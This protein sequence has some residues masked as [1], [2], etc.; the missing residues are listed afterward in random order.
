MEWKFNEGYIY[1]LVP[2]SSFL[3]TD[4]TRQYIY[5]YTYQYLCIPTSI[6]YT[7]YVAV[8]VRMYVL[9]NL[10]KFEIFV[11]W[12]YHGRVVKRSARYSGYGVIGQHVSR[13]RDYVLQQLSRSSRHCSGRT[14]WV[15]AYRRRKQSDI[16]IIIWQLLYFSTDRNHNISAVYERQ[17]ET[18]KVLDIMYL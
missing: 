17:Y 16:V 1:T 9:N 10:L 6:T 11:V 5:K 14:T 8:L 12:T 4:C 18:R 13:V 2:I 15:H 3:Y 7:Y